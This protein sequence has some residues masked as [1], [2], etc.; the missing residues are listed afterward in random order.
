M[1]ELLSDLRDSWR[2]VRRDPLYAAAVI[3]TLALT[4][5]ACIAV[6]SIV[7][8]VLLRPLE[9]PDPS[10]LVGRLVRYSGWLEPAT[11]LPIGDAMQPYLD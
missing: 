10:A 1:G 8:G 2:G 3:G 9:Y 5:G 7:N 4:L 6:F 11:T